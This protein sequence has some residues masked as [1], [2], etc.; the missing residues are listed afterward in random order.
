M[1]YDEYEFHIGKEDCQI[2][3]TNLTGGHIYCRTMKI[4]TK[5]IT[6]MTEGEL[7]MFKDVSITS[8][9]GYQSE[10]NGGYVVSFRT[11]H[12]S[13]KWMLEHFDI[14]QDGCRHLVEL[15]TKKCITCGYEEK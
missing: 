15:G 11:G 10:L 6:Y 8:Y 13:L 2:T 3:T 1:S 7:P 4:A 12:L 5:F 14:S 9:C